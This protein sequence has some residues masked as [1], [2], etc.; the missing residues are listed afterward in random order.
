MTKTR[1]GALRALSMGLCV[2]ASGC[3]MHA[4][5]CER[6]EDCGEGGVCVDG[7]CVTPDEP[8]VAAPP[9]DGAVEPAD[10]AGPDAAGPDVG[11]PDAALPAISAVG[12]DRAY[13]RTVEAPVLTLSAAFAVTR[14]DSPVE[15]AEV[16]FTVEEVDAGRIL[17]APPPASSDARGRVEARFET[18]L[19][20]TYV[21]VAT[22]VETGAQAVGPRLSVHDTVPSAR[23]LTSSC[24]REVVPAFLGRDPVTGY[25]LVPVR[26]GDCG[27]VVG[28]RL[29][30]AATPLVEVLSEAGDVGPVR[31]TPADLFTFPL[32]L[33][34]RA[35]P[36]DIDRP[37]P[38]GVPP[39]LPGFEPADGVLTLV[40]ATRGE[41][42]FID[43]D[44]DRRY[45]PAVDEHPPRDDLGE[46]FVD[47]DEDGLW[48]AG[49]PYLD[50]DGD[51]A[52][53]PADG[54]WSPSTLIWRPQTVLLT[55]ALD[56]A[57]TQIDVRCVGDCP[58]PEARP[59]ACSAGAPLVVGGGEAVVE[60]TATDA[61]GN[62]VVDALA[63]VEGDVEAVV[64][65]V[66]VG[67]ACWHTL[68][69]ER[70]PGAWTV[71]IRVPI[72]PAA[73]AGDAEVVVV[74][75]YVDAILEPR[76]HA[77]SVPICRLP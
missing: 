58:P 59:A 33:D 36:V 64:G 45:D 18:D 28:T 60:V 69:G 43:V 73:E 7:A 76:R 5:P 13:Q 26:V 49:E 35:G 6:H 75:R 11:P 29:A 46:P 24:E 23:A 53:T 72:A 77:L 66:P 42:A 12:G 55:G 51:G 74:V 44:G 50:G 3:V 65:P 57:R 70:V 47:L 39:G 21:V 8:D 48:S 71:P 41:E 40:V 20:G 22:L 62:C 34:G 61:N 27:G 63:E 67:A 2:W 31:W 54:V 15:G 56:E 30:G 16:E 32:V 52:W 1:G 19:P 14:G 10:D 4:A 17:P 68:P 9:P 25:D 37:A 38:P